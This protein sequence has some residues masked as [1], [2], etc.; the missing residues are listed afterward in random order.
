MW[1]RVYRARLPSFMD[2]E[3]ELNVLEHLYD[4]IILEKWEISVDFFINF[5][6]FDT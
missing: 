4:I 5:C 6:V 3:Q 2:F 1:I